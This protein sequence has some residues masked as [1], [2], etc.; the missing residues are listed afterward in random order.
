MLFDEPTSSLDPELTEEVLGVMRQLAD[1]GTTMIVVTHEMQFARDVSDQV[2]FLHDG[3]I[4]EA[5]PAG[6][7]CSPRRQIRPLPPVPGQDLKPTP[8]AQ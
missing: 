4:E 1:E 6:S 5:G 8:S 3:L 2:L 7:N